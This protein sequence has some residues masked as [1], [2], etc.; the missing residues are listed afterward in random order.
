[1]LVDEMVDSKAEWMVAR[2]VKLKVVYLAALMDERKVHNWVDLKV[3]W[4]AALMV[5]L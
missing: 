1:M 3:L 5:E 2:T 4:M